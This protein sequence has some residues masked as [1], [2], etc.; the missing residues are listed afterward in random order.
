MDII[1][2]IVTAD[3][4]NC[5]KDTIKVIVQGKGDYVLAFKGKQ[6][7]FYDEVKRYFDR[8]YMEGMK[9]EENFYKKTIEPEHGGSV[10][11]EYYITEVT[12]WY[13]EKKEWKKLCSFGIVCKTLK[14]LAGSYSIRAD[15]DEFERVACGHWG[16]ENHLHWQKDFT[17]RD[18]K[19]KSIAK[20]GAK[21]LQIMKKIA[22][23]ILCL[24]NESYKISMKRI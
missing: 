17:F 8:E 19:N 3:A 4:M 7:L 22:I 23:S 9:K 16:V 14:N 20:T 12:G 18:N 24:V 6:A 11:R 15:E 21:N 5:Q 1:N 2:T 13:S 10:T